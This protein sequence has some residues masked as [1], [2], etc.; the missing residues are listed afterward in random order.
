MDQAR[1]WRVAVVGAGPA[2]LYATEALQKRG[3]RVDVFE[4][5]HAPYGLVRYGVAPDHQKIKKTTA[6]FDRILGLP[7]VRLWLGVEI[8]RDLTLEELLESYD[9][10]LLT[11]GSSGARS[12]GIPGEGL[13]GSLAA[14]ELVG[15]YN[16][17]PDFAELDVPLDEPVAIVAG[18]GNVA[19]DVARVLLRDPAV[20]AQ[21]DIAESA[22]AEL[23]KSRVRQVLVLARRG[24]DQAA[25]DVK[26]V[27]DLMEMTRVEVESVGLRGEASTDRGELIAHLPQ[28][29]PEFGSGSRVVFRFQSSPVELLGDETGRVQ[30][31]RIEENHLRESAASLRPVGSGRTFTVDAGLFVRAIGYQGTPLPGVPFEAGSGTVP[32]DHGAVLTHPGGERV[33]KLYVAGWI[34]RGPTGLIGT[35]KADALETVITMEASLRHM[36]PERDAEDVLALLAERGSPRLDF[37]A[38]K[39]LDQWERAR[40]EARGAVREKIATLEQALAILSEQG[41][42]KQ[43]LGEPG[44]SERHLSET[45]R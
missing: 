42:G 22:L 19:I 34:K 11:T 38:W 9:Q 36:G 44:V 14:T 7:G 43:G 25:F 41:P 8:G 18:V 35:N 40:G 10:V 37:E 45:A 31:V 12:L 4:R 17:H 2:G 13:R 30:Q 16:G 20:L 6:V 1:N 21:T 28:A 23:R 39:K 5:L 24:P 27:R 3:A 29:A 33:R 32:N 26:E 15:W